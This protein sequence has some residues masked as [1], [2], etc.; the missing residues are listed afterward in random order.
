MGNL[1]V[2]G[3]DV[4]TAARTL[5]TA[6]YGLVTRH[7][8]DATACGS[9]TVADAVSEFALWLSVSLMTGTGQM[10]DAGAVARAAVDQVERTDAALARMA[11]S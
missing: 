5:E 7:D 1:A 9:A 2:R 4:R 10:A 8:L 11:S 3:G 6:G